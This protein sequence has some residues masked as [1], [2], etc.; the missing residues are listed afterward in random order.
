MD[1]ERTRFLFVNE[2][3]TFLPSRVPRWHRNAVNSH[4]Q[5]TTHHQR[6]VAAL[7]RL[8]QTVKFPRPGLHSELH[9]EVHTNRFYLESSIVASS[10]LWM[11]DPPDH[12]LCPKEDHAATERNDEN[13]QS[14]Q[15]YEDP[16]WL[17]LQLCKDG[18]NRDCPP[19]L[20]C[21]IGGLRIDPFKMYPIERKGC[22]S[23]AIDYCKIIR[24]SI[25]SILLTLL[26]SVVQVYA[27]LAIRAPED[28]ATAREET[29]FPAY[30]RTLLHDAM[31]F[32]QIVV[33]S[34]VLQLVHKG[35]E[36]QLSEE[37]LYRL[38]NVHMELGKRLQTAGDSTS[39]GVILTIMALVALNVRANH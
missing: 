5:H 7:L 32:E 24:L 16:S 1:G 2:D 25:S 11:R 33:F 9:T 13:Q 6:R 10:S 37:L 38:H 39:D 18:M 22:V 23:S 21:Q 27:P 19:S 12:F 17:K 31:L 29:I 28:T 26:C 8:K 15:R 20:I 35:F 4:V 30:F 34:E 3:D 14:I 36:V